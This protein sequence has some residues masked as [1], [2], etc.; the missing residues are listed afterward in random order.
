M[1][2]KYSI[3][4][5][6]DKR[7]V[8]A[9]GKYP[10]KLQVYTSKP[11][12]QKYYRTIFNLT[13]REFSQIWLSQKQSRDHKEIK[14]KI[15]AVES[16]ALDIAETIKPFTVEQFEKK[17]YLK[18][19]V[20]Q[21]VQYQYEETVRDLLLRGR[22]GTANTYEASL[23]SISG[24]LTAKHSMTIQVL[25]FS[26]VTVRWLNMYESYMIDH[27]ERSSATVGVY[28]RNLRAIYNKAIDDGEIDSIFYP[29]GE[30]KY[31]IPAKT[32]V[33]K[34]LSKEQVIIL[35]DSV[36]STP[37][38]QKAKDFWLLS[39][40]CSGMNMKDIALLT[41]KNIDADT[42]KF[43]R[44]KTKNT[45]KKNQMAITVYL[46]DMAKP[47]L[48][49]Y[50]KKG[51]APNDFVF[52]ILAKDMTLVQK[53]STVKRFTRFVNQHLKKL[54]QTLDLPQDISTIWARHSF[55]TIAINKGASMESVQESLGHENVS[56]T[57][58]YFA[59]FA[60]DVKKKISQSIID[61]D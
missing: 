1:T 2:P 51:T 49:K 4:I 5:I 41:N 42:I 53:H 48:N 43:Y 29:F 45:S 50:R 19:G 11:R 3:S 44:A 12:Q 60:D 23:K 8:K 52:D 58:G 28:M 35:R 54:C 46:N 22:I 13:E 21:S 38:Q 56:T 26:D 32:K 7:R 27:L 6:L 16:K 9:S 40:S 39:Y 57:K 34:A 55:S 36:P 33:K 17:L 20:G 18:D 10:V 30:K 25:T 14:R 59:G 31:E 24:Y 61:L 37:E 47:I 15:Q